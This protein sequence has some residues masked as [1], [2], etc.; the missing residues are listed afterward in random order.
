VSQN[1]GQKKKENGSN[2]QQQRLGH[3]LALI[4]KRTCQ[5]RS[6]DERNEKANTGKEKTETGAKKKRIESTV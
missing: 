5:T 3:T 6:L 4:Q 1:G 2:E